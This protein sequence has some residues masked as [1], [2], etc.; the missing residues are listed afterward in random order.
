MLTIISIL[1][2]FFC[3]MGLL[4]FFTWLILKKEG[5]YY[6]P[7]TTQ[8]KCGWFGLLNGETKTRYIQANSE[9]DVAPIAVCPKCENEL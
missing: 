3:M 2:A 4:L 1:T 5:K 7:E 6:E 8:C 9:G